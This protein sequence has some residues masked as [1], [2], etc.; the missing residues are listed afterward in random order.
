M[1][2]LRD[3]KNNWK[4]VGLVAFWNFLD[5]KALPCEVFYDRR[6]GRTVIFYSVNGY[7]EVAKIEYGLRVDG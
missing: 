6:D 3:E 1:Y 7:E 2:Y 4:D 5:E